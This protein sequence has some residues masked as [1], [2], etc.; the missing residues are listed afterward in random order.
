MTST[1][2]QLRLRASSG[3]DILS[4]KWT[5][6][7]T[8]NQLDRISELES[9]R[10][11]GLNK[12]GNK[13][14]FTQNKADELAELVA[15]R[16]TPKDMN[17]LPTGAKSHIEE[18]VEKHVYN[19]NDHVNTFEMEKGTVCEPEGIDLYNTMFF[20]NYVKSESTLKKGAWVGHPDV[21]DEENKIL[22]DCKL[23]YTKKQMP[24]T[25]EQMRSYVTSG[26]YDWQV[27]VYMYM[28][29]WTKGRVFCALVDTPEDLIKHGHDLSL[30]EMH[31]VP[32]ELRVRC[33]DVELTKDDVKRIKEREKAAQEY[34]TFYYNQITNNV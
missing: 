17:A 22:L 8:Q 33:Y 16:D 24:K 10:D 3:A 25:D 2:F 12:N 18:L 30:H 34:A 31:D 26:G 28:K 7:L 15:R 14:S 1:K 4:G 32:M 5:S 19:Y 21:E 20:T 9:E 6:E 29:G 13:V 11:T 23:P 27:K